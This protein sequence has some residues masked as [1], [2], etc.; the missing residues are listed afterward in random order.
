MIYIHC[1]NLG[2]LD[3]L[4]NTLPLLEATAKDFSWSIRLST[5]DT[6]TDEDTTVV[7]MSDD[8]ALSLFWWYCKTPNQIQTHIEALLNHEA[9]KNKIVKQMEWSVAKL[10]FARNNRIFGRAILDTE[11]YMAN[12]CEDH[13]E[14]AHGKEL[15]ALL[16]AKGFEKFCEVEA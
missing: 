1:E 13:I 2:L 5:E 10:D 11:A 14:Y 3:Q 12:E 7:E 6:S 4:V 9:M 16:D 15:F 8:M